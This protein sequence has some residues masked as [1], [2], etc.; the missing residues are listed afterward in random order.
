MKYSKQIFDNVHGFIG[1]TEEELKIVTHPLFQRLRRVHQLG[2]ASYVFPG[3]EHTRF[4]HSL[5][6]MFV[7]NEMSQALAEKGY[8]KEN[9]VIKLR[10]AALLHD[11]GHYPLS[12]TSEEVMVDL[13]GKDAKH[14]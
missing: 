4:A 7:A 9:D 10:L 13:Y 6:A 5:G 12:H 8:L 1:L 2:M 11:I 3:A 14:E